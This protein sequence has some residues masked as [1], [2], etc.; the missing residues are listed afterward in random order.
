MGDIEKAYDS[1]NRSSL[2]VLFDFLNRY[3]ARFILLLVSITVNF[4]MLQGAVSNA[5]PTSSG[6]AQ[7]SPLSP[8]LF[9]IAISSLYTTQIINTESQ[10]FADDLCYTSNN[11]EQLK[12]AIVEINQNLSQLG[13]RLN[14]S[15]SVILARTRVDYDQILGIHISYNT[16]RYLGYHIN[17]KGI[18]WKVQIGKKYTSLVQKSRLLR[19]LGVFRS[20][21]PVEVLDPILSAHILPLID[22]GL[23]NCQKLPQVHQNKIDV[24]I[25]KILKSLLGCPM[26]FS[27]GLLQNAWRHPTIEQRRV[28]S[29]NKQILNYAWL[30]QSEVPPNTVIKFHG[31]F[32]L[33]EFIKNNIQTHPEIIQLLTHNLRTTTRNQ[34]CPLCTQT[35]TYA[36][37]SIKCYLSHNNFLFNFSSTYPIQPSRSRTTNSISQIPQYSNNATLF[38]TDASVSKAHLG[39]GIVQLNASMH[40]Q[41]SESIK[42]INSSQIT[43]PNSTELEMYGISRC[44]DHVLTNNIPISAILCDNQAAIDI[45]NHIKHGNDYSKYSYSHLVTK[46]FNLV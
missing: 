34:V 44:I 46:K 13:L 7:G 23:Q 18:D 17:A 30:S 21:M 24:F 31:G 14:P 2:F 26:S 29:Y 33:N 1:L 15:K 10:F 43:Y 4:L 5:V 40:E 9:N 38:V 12:R 28:Y 3:I 6:V 8:I 27:N 22:F 11:I 32:K 39:I 36:G 16:H 20:G 25:R 41:S 35:H 45:C 42:I 37:A 19:R